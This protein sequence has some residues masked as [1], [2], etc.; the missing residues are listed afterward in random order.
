[1]KTIGTILREL[2]EVKGLLLREVG[3]SLSID[4]TILSKI[5]R[6]GRM[7]TK[8]QVKALAEFYNDNK[9][10]VLIAW[11]SDKVVYFI[12]DED[13]ALQAMEVAEEKV[14]YIRNE[15]KDETDLSQLKK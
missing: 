2:R 4:P 14:R 5:E 10:D 9:N 12:Q 13:L 8:E 15:M 3:A 6:D 7:P 11:L 1:M